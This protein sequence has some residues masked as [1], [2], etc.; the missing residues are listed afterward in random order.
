[1]LASVHWVSSFFSFQSLFKSIIS[2]DRWCHEAGQTDHQVPA[3]K[4]TLAEAGVALL[5]GDTPL[6]TGGL[7]PKPRFPESFSPCLHADMSSEGHILKF[8]LMSPRG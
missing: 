1:M 8:L 2:W 5:A 4:W 6:E 7:E 3:Q